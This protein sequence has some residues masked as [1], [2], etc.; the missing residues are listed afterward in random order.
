MSVIL[1]G[2]AAAALILFSSWWFSAHQM[3]VRAMRKVERCSIAAAPH[4]AMVRV[5]GTLHEGAELLRAPLS[6]RSCVG[7]W[8]QVQVRRS[9]NRSLHWANLIDQREAVDFVVE[10]GSGS[11]IVQTRDVELAIELDHHQT[12]GTFDDATPVEESFLRRHGHGSTGLFGFNKALRYREAVL[13]P[14][15]TV[16]VVGRA[17]WEDDPA[18]GA[19]QGTGYRQGTRA[20]R[21]V[22]EASRRMPLRISDDPKAHA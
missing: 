13:E 20:T 21:L 6:G 16:V 2:G 19:V 4:G 18:P 8:V 22:L 11:A 3:T 12:S 10:D 7:Y 14:G 1:L 5:T 9:A 15:E 17:R